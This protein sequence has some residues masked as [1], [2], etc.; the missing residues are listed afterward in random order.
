LK[1]HQQVDHLRLHRASADTGS[2]V[3]RQLA[4]ARF[5]PM[6]CRCPP[7]NSWEPL[8]VCRIEADDANSSR[9]RARLAAPL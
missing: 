7:L 6:R 1:I 4:R 8:K 9:T 5:R 3:E 2:S